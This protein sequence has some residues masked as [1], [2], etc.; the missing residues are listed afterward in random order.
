MIRF[1]IFFPFL[2]RI[3]LSSH[4]LE[5]LLGLGLGFGLGCDY[6]FLGWGMELEVVDGGR[7]GRGGQVAFFG[8]F[9]FFMRV[10]FDACGFLLIGDVD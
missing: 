2:I 8:F 3:L 9:W 5:R 7:R 6:W 4:E 1:F 10:I